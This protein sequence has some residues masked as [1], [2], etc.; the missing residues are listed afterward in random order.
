MPADGGSIDLSVLTKADAD[1]D[2]TTFGVRL[3][4]GGEL[5]AGITISG[6]AIEV[7]ASVPAG[8]YELEIFATD[9]GAQSPAIPFTLTKSEVEE[10]PAPFMTFILAGWRAK[11]SRLITPTRG[12]NDDGTSRSRPVAIQEALATSICL[13]MVAAGTTPEPVTCRFRPDASWVGNSLTLNLAVPSAGT[14]DMHFRY[15]SGA[16]LPGRSLLPLR[17]M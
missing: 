17:R 8:G 16:T 3:A 13:S 11:G 2:A 4:G 9:G 5:P 10:E 15:A 12:N 6:N 1:G 14:Y 7:A